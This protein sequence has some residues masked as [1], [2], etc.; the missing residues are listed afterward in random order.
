MASEVKAVLLV[1]EFCGHG[2]HVW[3]DIFHP[4]IRP[5][6]DPTPELPWV[7]ERVEPIGR[8]CVR[9]AARTVR[10]WARPFLEEVTHG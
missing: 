2:E 5:R 10:H 9:C 7:T 3:T 1:P 4:D 6:H 8:C